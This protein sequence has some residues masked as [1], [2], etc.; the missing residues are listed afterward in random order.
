[1]PHCPSLHRSPLHIARH[2]LFGLV[3]V[4]AFAVVFGAV[5]MLAWNYT[6]PALFGLPA[7]T[8]AQAVAALV[9]VRILT[10]RFTHHHHR[11][12]YHRFRRSPAGDG[13]A[14]Y[15]AW[16]DEEGEAAFHAYAARQL[17]DDGRS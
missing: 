4:S 17:G 6:M 14:L 5:V 2:L 15:S 9:L 7:L 12:G 13:A 10:G 11:H 1:M 16:W 3:L 8:F